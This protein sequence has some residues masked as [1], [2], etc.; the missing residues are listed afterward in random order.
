MGSPSTPLLPLLL[1]AACTGGTLG[2]GDDAPPGDGGVR[3]DGVPGGADAAPARPDAPPP[4]EPP[5]L[6]GI[7]AAHNEV[8]ASVGTPPLTWDPALAAIAQGWAEQCVD[9]AAPAGLIDHN[10][11]RSD[12]YPAYVGEN[13]FG[14]SA[15]TTGAAAVSSWASEGAYWHNDTATC[16]SGR[17]CG[18]YTQVVWRTTTK[19]G[20][21]VHACPGLA[22]GHSIVCNY[23]PGGNSG[24]PAY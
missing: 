7:T 11:D 10:A 1:L 21:G 23:A 13:I 2:G 4:D 19:L 3:P 16:D 24:G 14:S 5:A 18:H 9:V 20:C 6:A 17:V 12:T 22:Y 15:A 8:R